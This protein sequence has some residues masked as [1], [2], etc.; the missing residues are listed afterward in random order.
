MKHLNE[1]RSVPDTDGGQLPQAPDSPSPVLLQGLP[2]IL[3]AD[4]ETLILGS[5]P[6]PASLAA[7]RYYAHRQNQF[8][9]LL[10]AVL[11]EP[12][13]DADYAEKQRCLLAHGIGVWDIYRRC[14]R[15]GALD[16]A[17]RQA[18]ANDF[19]QLAHA[20]PRLRR[21]CFNGQVSARLARWFGAQGYATH[22]LPSSSPAYTLPFQN[23]LEAWRAALAE[24]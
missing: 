14:V 23:K 9:R 5:F 10:G 7:R 8:W 4:I 1:E 19:S 6:S 11:D 2:P 24:S 22:V 3:D 18:E 15:Q 12:L 20:A 13:A 17:I 21:V 16:T